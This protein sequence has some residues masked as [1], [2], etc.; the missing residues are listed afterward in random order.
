[1]SDTDIDFM[2][3]AAAREYV[4]NYIISLKRTQKDRAVAEEELEQWQRRVRLADSR[5][6]PILKKSAESQVAELSSRRQRLLDEE[7]QLK[8][9]VDVLKEKLRSLSI[10]SSLSVDT[11]TLLAQLS[12]LVGEPAPSGGPAGGGDTLSHRLKEE[13]AT[14]ALEELKR[15]M[16]EEGR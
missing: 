5:G 6:E 13:E 11:E 1:M 15:K 14:Q 12:V 16:K 9:K 10:R 2:D 3:P 7:R 8:A 4:L